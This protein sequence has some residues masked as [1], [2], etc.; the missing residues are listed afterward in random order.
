MNEPPMKRKQILEVIRSTVRGSDKSVREFHP[1]RTLVELSS[2][3]QVYVTTIGFESMI[4]DL[5]SNTTLM[6]SKI[7]SEINSGSWWSTATEYECRT[8][9]DVLWPL[10]FFY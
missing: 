7:L 5:L 6:T 1:K 2:R 4:K 10:V 8:E 3:R 9:T